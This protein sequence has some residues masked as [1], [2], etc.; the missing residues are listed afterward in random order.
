MVVSEMT[1]LNPQ[2][3]ETE[4][5]DLTMGVYQIQQTK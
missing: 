3:N 5:R 4:L 2:P 1:E